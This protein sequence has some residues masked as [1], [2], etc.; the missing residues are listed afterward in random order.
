MKKTLQFLLALCLLLGSIHSVLAQ[1]TFSKVAVSIESVD[2]MEQLNSLDLDLD[3]FETINSNTIAFFVTENE[4]AALENS[5]FNFEVLIP[6]YAEYYANMVESDLP[7]VENMT[8]GAM[9]ANGFDLG[10][11][12]GFYTLAEMEAK[13]DEMKA[14]F[15]NLITTKTSIGTTEEGRSIW[16]VK[17]SDNPDVDEAEAAVY[18]DGLHHAREPS[19]MAVTINYMFWLLENYATDPAVQYL[20]DNRE[21]YFVPVVNPDG[22]FYNQQ[23][24]P[25]G[26]GMWRKNRSVNAGSSC[27][28]VDLN[29]NYSFGYANDPSCSSTN[30]CSGTYR[31]PMAFSEPEAIAVRDLMVQI[32]PNTGFSTH[33]TAG[34][35]LMPYGFNST[36]PEFEIYSEWASTFASDNNYLYGTTSQMLGYTSCGTTRDYLH[37]EGIYT[38]TPEIGG[39][40]FWPPPSTIF[41]LVDENVYP[42]FF[43][44]WIAGAYLD[45][46]SHE[47][48][49]PV[50]P[51][52]NFNLVV[53]VKNIGLEDTLGDVTIGLST[54]ASGISLP[55]NVNLGSLA[56]RS[57]VDNSTNPLVVGIDPGFSDSSF[58]LTVSTYQDGIIN[59]SMDIPVYIGAKTLYFYDDAENGTTAWTTSGSGSSWEV[60]ND[61]SYSGTRSFGDSDGG[62]GSNNV[63]NYFSLDQPFDF[64]NAILPVVSFAAKWAIDNGDNVRFQYSINGGS[65]WQD[66]QTFTQNERW[67]IRTYEL[68]SLTGE[69]N[70]LFRF[71]MQSN[72]NTPGDGFYFDDFEVSDYDL[73]TLSSGGSIITESISVYPNPFDE[74][75]TIQFSA[76]LNLI[77]RNI[78]LFDIQGR[79]ISVTSEVKNNTIQISTAHLNSGLYLLKV[80]NENGQTTALKK[81][82]KL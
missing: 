27:R 29:R 25:N 51:G 75:L 50:S 15:P 60:L 63:L 42:M 76:D 22:Y 36:P 28:G 8:R 82:V 31:G 78:E 81:I 64:S 9:V 14:N 34:T 61:D 13:L 59:E 35:Y 73:N 46:Q 57:R 43:Q 44:S 21:L 12:G 10:T 65:N 66:L 54:T 26:G 33:S 68:N 52:Q 37:S 58:I 2:S 72:N 32:Q 23:T 62:N 41:S 6:D 18:F 39:S 1:E 79:T 80:V 69:S 56:A 38:W 45:V 77:S 49:D 71:R 30:P 24:D 48:I 5:G 20:V 53:E 16:M 4:K 3:H 17:I 7:N 74:T 70:V 55:A 67:N 40:G 11:M 19:A 47:P